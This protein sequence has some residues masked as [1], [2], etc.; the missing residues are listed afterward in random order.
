MSPTHEVRHV[1]S[2]TCTAAPLAAVG[3]NLLTTAVVNTTRAPL[4]LTRVSPASNRGSEPMFPSV[5]SS[6]AAATGCMSA[7]PAPAPK[8][9]LST[10]APAACSSELLRAL[11]ACL[12]THAPAACSS[13]LPRALMEHGFCTASYLQQHS[14]CMVERRTACDQGGS[15]CAGGDAVQRLPPL[16]LVPRHHAQP[17]WRRHNVSASGAHSDM[18]G[19]VQRLPKWSLEREFERHESCSRSLR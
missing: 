4:L 10:H 11:D 16:G 18:I 5:P 8:A 13:E 7:A 1:V 3:S 2:H 6:G 15:L 12:S 9:C 14:H 19:L 17:T